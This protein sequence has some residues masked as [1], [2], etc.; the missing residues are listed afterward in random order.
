VFRKTRC[1]VNHAHVAGSRKCKDC[2][3]QLVQ[4]LCKLCGGW[5][6]SAGIADHE[7]RCKKK[8][9]LPAEIPSVVVRVVYVPPTRNRGTYFFEDETHFPSSTS[10]LE[11]RDV[12]DGAVGGYVVNAY[13]AVFAQL[14]ANKVIHVERVL[15]VS[16][17]IRLIKKRRH[18]T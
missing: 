3:N 13:D 15:E 16:S 12:T 11:T 18:L 2:S 5:K 7:N 17:V 1:P 9:T 14:E 6:A 10:W 8:K 4:A